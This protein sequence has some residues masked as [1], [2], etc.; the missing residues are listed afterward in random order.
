MGRGYSR[1]TVLM[2]AFVVRLLQAVANFSRVAGLACASLEQ[3][4]GLALLI[5]APESS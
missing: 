5:F 1:I 2:E 4:H 3:Q